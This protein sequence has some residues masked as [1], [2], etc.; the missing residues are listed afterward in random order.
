M[1]TEDNNNDTGRLLNRSYNRYRNL[2]YQ[3]NTKVH[4]DAYTHRCGVPIAYAARLCNYANNV[5]RIVQA[6]RYMVFNR[7]HKLLANKLCLIGNVY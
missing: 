7:I 4:T 3:K 1:D 2:L 6:Y 5:E